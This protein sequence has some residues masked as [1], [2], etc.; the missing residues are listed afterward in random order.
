MSEGNLINAIIRHYHNNPNIYLWRANSGCFKTFGGQRVTCN[1]PGCP[2]II[3]FIAPIGQFVG[4]E[5]K[6]TTKQ[7]PKQAEFQEEVQSRG[8]V[9]ILARSLE[10]VTCLLN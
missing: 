7:E 3:G 6:D 1:F 8:G 9:Y 5:T 2:D 4:I 10:D